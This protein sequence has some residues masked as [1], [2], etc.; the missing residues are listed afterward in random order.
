MRT[1]VKCSVPA[2][3]I[4]PNR[5]YSGVTTELHKHRRD[6]AEG[7]QDVPAVGDRRF[8]QQA[9][10]PTTGTATICQPKGDG[11]SLASRIPA[12]N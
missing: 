8:L 10:C 7:R 11:Y 2:T 1:S 4:A 5:A 9:A 12:W 6:A 3:A